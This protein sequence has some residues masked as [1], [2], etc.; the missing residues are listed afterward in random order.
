M[1]WISDAA[2]DRSLISEFTMSPDDPNKADP[3]SERVLMEIA[4]P[5]KNH[6]GGSLEFGP[7]GFL[8]I[9]LGDGG[10]R[11]DPKASGQDLS[12]LL[13]S[14]LRI[15]VDQP[16]SGKNYG[17]PADN[18]CVNVEGARPDSLDGRVAY[19]RR[20]PGHGAC[21]LPTDGETAPG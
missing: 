5:Y 7:D 4:Q 17:I 18:P 9:G 1:E 11:N 13:G 8:Y 20:V 12:M 2:Q 16:S 15:D 3:N 14:I 6:N 19:R 10:D 21:Y